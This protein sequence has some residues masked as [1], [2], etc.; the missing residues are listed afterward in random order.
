[1]NNL[2][3]SLPVCSSP[4]VH[5]WSQAAASL[6]LAAVWEK[7]GGSTGVEGNGRAERS[8]KTL[9]ECL[10]CTLYFKAEATVGLFKKK[11]QKNLT[12]FFPVPK[13]FFFY[14][15]VKSSSQFM[16]CL[17]NFVLFSGVLPTTYPRFKPPSLEFI[18]I[19]AKRPAGKK[20]RHQWL[21]C[22]RR[23]I[24]V[25]FIL[26]MPCDALIWLQ[27]TRRHAS[28]CVLIYVYFTH[29]VVVIVVLPAHVMCQGQ[30]KQYCERRGSNG[31][32]QCSYR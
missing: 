8:T 10:S 15:Y 9:H 26:M 13:I 27:F 14:Y 23:C 32:L 12:L 19:L 6:L 5:K 16:S 17:A 20:G 18:F 3:P 30:R 29:S 2:S 24:L 4:S 11:K 25:Q 31:S 7:T 21:F 28:L 22:C 1:M